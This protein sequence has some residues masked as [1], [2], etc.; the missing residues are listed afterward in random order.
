MEKLLETIKARKEDRVS[1]AL[2]ILALGNAQFQ[3]D[4]D[5][6]HL[7]S[8][9]A[10][11]LDD[12]AVL[13]K[14]ID[15]LKIE[16]NT[17]TRELLISFLPYINLRLL[18]TMDALTEIILSNFETASTKT[19]NVLATLLGQLI[20]TNP[21]IAENVALF[22]KKE[23]HV[24]V[25]KQLA[26]VLIH[27]NKV[28]KELAGIYE[29]LLS[30][31]KEQQQ[32]LLL[33]KLIES[34]QLKKSTLLKYLHP[35]TPISIKLLLLDYLRD[36]E[37]VPIK[38][39][40]SLLRQEA[41]EKVRAHI[42]QVFIHDSKNINKH[43]TFL[44]KYISDEQDISVRETLLLFLNENTRMTDQM[45]LFYIDLLKTEKDLDIS[46]R[47]A[48]ILTPYLSQSHLKTSKVNECFFNLLEEPKSSY[49]I[50]LLK[51]I[52]KQLGKRITFDEVLFERML[53]I[54]KKNTD[55]EIQKSILFSFCNSS[56]LDDR[57]TP[58][59][60]DAIRSPTPLIREYA[61]F[62]LLPLPLTKNNIPHLLAAIPLLLDNHL[63]EY[64]REYLA[65]RIVSIPNIG[66]EWIA[67]LENIAKNGSGKERFI[68]ERAYELALQAQDLTDGVEQVDWHL[69]EN[70]I[71]V[72]KRTGHI[73]PDIFIHYDSKPG[74]ANELLKTVLIDADCT[75]S[76]YNSTYITKQD[77]MQ[78][79]IAKKLIDK[80]IALFCLGYL[81]TEARNKEDNVF[82]VALNNY[83]DIHLLKEKLWVFFERNLT[84][85]VSFLN[86]LLLRNTLSKAYKNDAAL[87]K[88]FLKK[89]TSFTNEKAATPY[90]EFLF[91]SLDWR[92]TEEII[93]ELLKRPD[94]INNNIKS[95]FDSFVLKLG[96][97]VPFDFDS[98]PGFSN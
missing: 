77:I 41:N 1:Q 59:Y 6:R 48:Q 65:L 66:K 24:N 83:Q 12:P 27:L 85:H 70:K 76:L 62:G 10:R 8:I 49:H 67:E 35:T 51:Y 28:P 44:K 29:I 3:S 36:R 39:L 47:V 92:H 80:E 73:F 18:K 15:F 91:T 9:A 23:Q 94:L 58:I 60:V 79:L 90:I 84:S 69:W 14:W 78:F 52:S 61:C 31:L 54:Y 17:V 55:V 30:H 87:A 95:K 13:E 64:V 33:N 16:D 88:T 74:L 71:K 11:S 26:E 50:E 19:K 38:Q 2:A 72:K 89:L 68:C 32:V 43:F 96:K 20:K 81:I 21:A 4:E 82:L 57:L 22:L 86:N 37:I 40:Q 53:S 7:L 56:K 93:D 63:R 42:L 45:I 75:D 5:K 97:E 25:K 34:N 46:W 98:T